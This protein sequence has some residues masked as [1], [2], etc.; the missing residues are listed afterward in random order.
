MEQR[1]KN[2]FV[3]NIITSPLHINES[4]TTIYMKH[5]KGKGLIRKQYFFQLYDHMK[6]IEKTTNILKNKT[7]AKPESIKNINKSMV[8]KVHRES[9][10]LKKSDNKRILKINKTRGVKKQVGQHSYKD[11]EDM[12]FSKVGIERKEE[13]EYIEFETGDF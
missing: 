5:L 8:D 6:A 11:I 1:I 3:Y 13:P 9:P 7:N 2:R 4:K 12:V 10:A